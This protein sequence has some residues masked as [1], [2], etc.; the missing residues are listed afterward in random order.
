MLVEDARRSQTN[1]LFIDLEFI[2]FDKDPTILE[3]AVVVTDEDFNELHRQWWVVGLSA[4]EIEQRVLLGPN[5]KFHKKTSATNGLLDEVC[6]SSCTMQQLGD[7]LM[8]VLRAHFPVPRLCRLVGNSVYMDWQ[9]LAANL[10]EVHKHLSH[11]VIDVSTLIHCN[12]RHNIHFPRMNSVG[13][14]AV[15]DTDEALRYMR[16]HDDLLKRLQQ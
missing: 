5:A 9:V 15:N 12:K 2:D 4:E 10:P 11:K 8:G 16:L 13:H 1:L 6:A 14:R 3:C 7:E